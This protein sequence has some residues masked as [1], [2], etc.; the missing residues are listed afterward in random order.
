MP[1]RVENPFT[2]TSDEIEPLLQT[3]RPLLPELEQARSRIETVRNSPSAQTILAQTAPLMSDIDSLPQTRYTDYRLFRATG[4]RQRYQDPYGRK[5]GHLTAAALRL[6]F[7]ETD[8]KDS[9]QDHIWSICEESDWVVPAHEGH[10]LIDL[11]AAETGFTLAETLHLLGDTLDAEIRTRVRQEVDRRIFTPYIRAHWAHEWYYHGHGNWNGVCNGSI[12]STFLLLEPE[13]GRVAI[14][15][16]L[17]LKGLQ[18]YLKSAFAEDGSSSEGVHCWRY[19]LQNFVSLSEMLRARSD[20]V[21]DLL[22]SEKIRRIAAFPA[23]VQFTSTQFATFSD[24]EEVI[25]FDAG[26]I[27]RLGKR[28]GDETLPGVLGNA[29]EMR[30]L[31]DIWRLP[32]QLRNVLWWDG[33]AGEMNA[34]EDAE[35]PSG[36]I[37]RLSTRTSS[38]APVIFLIKAGHNAQNHN[39][40]DIGSFI[41][42][43]D[44]ETLLTDPG[45]GLFTRQY[46]SGGRYDNIFANSYGHSVPRIG[47]HLQ[48]PG[49]QY[50][51]KFFGIDTTNGARPAK[52][53]AIDLAGAYPVDGLESIHREVT[54]AT[55]G[56]DV[57]TVWLHDT[58]RFAHDPEVVEEAVVTWRDVTIEGATALVHGER[59]TLRLTIEKPHGVAF[60]VERLEEESR[61]N[62]KPGILKRLRIVLPAAE[63]TDVRVRMDITPTPT[64]A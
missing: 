51:G 7:G 27:S 24:S 29:R 43:V 64:R 23:K 53:V 5:R 52:R 33:V 50:Q 59:H 11:M 61:I 2:L 3:D 9:V 45:R 26:I 13:P 31:G 44:G 21:I 48:A 25:E 54:L 16:E 62:G 20:G 40:N 30:S 6:F 19:G 63:T 56:D 60:E 12:A 1:T 36:E 15:L 41:L 39:Q 47:Q 14:A 38:G 17:A 22:A 10:N 46:F 4:D 34:P 28:T 32:M 58:T 35:L 18:T 37:A 8:L 55:S 49:R 57:G 42:H